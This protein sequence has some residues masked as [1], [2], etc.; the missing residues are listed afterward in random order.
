MEDEKYKRKFTMYIVDF[1]EWITDFNL[2][3]EQEECCCFVTGR[4]D[5]ITDKPRK[6]YKLNIEEAIWCIVDCNLA[7]NKYRFKIYP[8]KEFLEEYEK[9]KN[10]VNNKEN[11]EW[12]QETSDGLVD[13]DNILKLDKKIREADFAT[14]NRIS[15]WDYE[16]KNDISERN[17]LVTYYSLT[18]DE[19]TD[20]E[21]RSKLNKLIE[22]KRPDWSYEFERRDRYFAIS[23]PIISIKKTYCGY[24]VETI[25][26]IYRVKR[27]ISPDFHNTVVELENYLKSDEFKK[28]MNVWEK[29]E[30]ENS[31]Q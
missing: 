17:G 9:Y 13:F 7:Y 3:Y 28:F 22:C 30:M 29:K 8:E 25:K 11:F 2:S 16:I 10:D 15:F 18:A 20:T 26:S 4:L 24:D 23:T 19:F 27:I 5:A 14:I 21:A 12:W 31:K 6:P 1:S